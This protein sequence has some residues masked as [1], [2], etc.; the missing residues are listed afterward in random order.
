MDNIKKADIHI[1]VSKDQGY[2]A[3]TDFNKKCNNPNRK[4]LQ[5]ST[6]RELLD[7][8]K[9]VNEENKKIELEKAEEN[10]PITPD[11]VA[12]EWVEP[13]TN[14]NKAFILPGS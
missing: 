8:L 7:I 9:N 4:I 10:K 1:I 11:I 3:F 6:D 14:K 5:I 13:T 2:K 12:E